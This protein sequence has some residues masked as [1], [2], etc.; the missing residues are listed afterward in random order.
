MKLYE[1]IKEHEF[2]QVKTHHKDT[3]PDLYNYDDEDANW[4][5]EDLPPE[6]G[7]P[8]ATNPKIKN[9]GTGAFSSAYQHKD[10]PYDVAKGSK[11]TN[12]PDGFKAFFMALADDKEAQ[13]NPYFPRFR[14]INIFKQKDD[15]ADDSRESYMV[16]MEPLEPYDKLSKA[17]R[18]M[19]INKIF[20]EH[21]IDV[22]NHYIKKNPYYNAPGWKL[23]M[24]VQAALEN[25]E[26]GDE[27]RWQIE[28]DKFKEAIEFLQKTAKEYDYEFD[29]HS[30]NL[31]VRRTSV[32][33]QLV[34][35]DPLG[36][37]SAKRREDDDDWEP[38]DVF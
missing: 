37:S 35:N 12:I 24:A 34:L 1:I 2:P 18:K 20:S 16:K 31:M 38:E 25:Q 14:N 27:L 4:D 28:D 30:G 36:F 13:A 9:L 8:H 3:L 17:E 19:L 33:P 21:G 26:W 15:W 7:N 23:A 32:G 5:D 11:A 6:K 29:L 10:N 22:I